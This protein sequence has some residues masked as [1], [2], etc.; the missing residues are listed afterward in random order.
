MPLAAQ[1]AT[2]GTANAVAPDSVGAAAG[3]QNPTRSVNLPLT[4]LV[5]RSNASY[6]DFVATDGTEPDFVSLTNQL[7]IEWDDDTDG[8]GANVAD[9]QGVG[10]TFVVPPNYA[11]G[12]V[13]VPVVF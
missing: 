11:S 8:A 13:F 9:N 10:T 5:M 2:A 1:S 7:M 12:G 6:V 4:S 3:I